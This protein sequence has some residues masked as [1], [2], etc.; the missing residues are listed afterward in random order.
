MEQRYIQRFRL[1]DRLC[2][3][4]APA[5]LA[6][7][8]VLEDTKQPR[9]VAQLKFKSVADR[10]IGTVSGTLRCLDGTGRT[11]GE[12]PFAY[13]DL[14]A[15]RGEAFGQYTAIVLP[16]T[17]VRA[18][19]LAGLE[20]CFAD[21]SAWTAPAKAGWE[22]LPPFE[23]L[24]AAVGDPELLA[25]SRRSLPGGK[26]AYAAR[27]GLWYC[28]CGGV[29]RDGESCCHRCGRDRDQVTRYAAPEGLEAL[30]QELREEEARRAE[31]REQAR[32][33]AEAKATALKAAAGERARQLRDRFTKKAPAEEALPPD[34]TAETAPLAAG[35]AGETPA[36]ETASDL[37]AVSVPAEAAAPRTRSGRARKTA[38]KGKLLAGIGVLAVLA[39][40]AA[41]VLPR[42]LGG[43]AGELHVTTPGD[44]GEVV[45]LRVQED[46]EGV[47]AVTP[48][49]VRDL[50]PGA[51][52]I[53]FG[54][55]PDLGNDIHPYLIN[56]YHM[57]CLVT[58]HGEHGAGEDW[59]SFDANRDP[60]SPVCLLVFG[61][62]LTRLVG[63]AIN[64]PR[65]A[66]GGDWEL[67]VT[68]CDY[69][70]GDLVEEETERF[71]AGRD[72]IF[73]HRIQAEDI[74]D[75]GAEWFLFGYNTGR[76][77]TLLSDDPQAYHIWSQYTS[78]HRDQFARALDRAAVEDRLPDLGR[79]RCFLL[80][81]DDRE[82]LGYTMLDHSGSGGPTG[83]SGGIE[84]LGTVDLYLEEENNRITLNDEVLQ[85]VIPEEAF[86]NFEGYAIDLNGDMDAYLTDSFHMA[87]L[88]TSEGTAWG[89][90]SSAIWDPSTIE[91]CTL[92]VYS[93]FT[94]LCGYFIGVPEDLG[95]GRWRIE[96]TL[97]DYDFTQLYAAQAEGYDIAPQLPEISESQL[98]YSGATWFIEP[99]QQLSG[100]DDFTNRVRLQ[101]LWSRATS[102]N[103]RL[104]ARPIEELPH[105][106][107][108]ATADRPEFYL[109][110]NADYQ[111][112]GYVRITDGERVE[113]LTL[114][115]PA[116]G[117]TTASGT[118]NLDLTA[119][120]GM[121]RLEFEQ[122]QEL[123]PQAERMELRSAADLGSIEEYLRISDST[124]W[125]QA[126]GEPL[127]QSN[128]QF[129]VQNGHASFRS[130]L[131]YSGPTRL[132]G[133]FIGE[134]VH[135]GGDTWRME[136]TLCDY[137]FS[138]LL[139]QEKQAFDRWE[140][141]PY[142][143][144]EDADTTGAKYVITG[145]YT[146]SE[147]E[148]DMDTDEE[149]QL[150]L[151]WSHS[152]RWRVERL[153]QNAEHLESLRPE[154][155]DGRFA[156]VYCLLLD[157]D[158]Q[159]V[160]YTILTN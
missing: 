23:P 41:V 160:A 46:E 146:A 21:G 56:S 61:Q 124:A 94:R 150:Y 39:V 73:S 83:G 131:I 97:C 151:L 9:L 117:G 29:N 130:L 111:Y 2:C 148:R 147:D 105:T 8:R 115:P 120:N 60:D 142:V 134:P 47:C 77:P 92:M 31:A 20:V 53:S 141:P 80:L 58:S 43:G 35:A 71:E 69:D 135:E 30:R 125:M 32:R 104:F 96:I 116:G 152:Q 36:S 74:A 28:T 149:A 49:L 6:A 67:D 91:L 93:D 12:V 95:G 82:L 1:P 154:G 40:L 63:Y 156:W 5:V 100:N 26:Y 129:S 155:P 14:T 68:L 42:V 102:P 123:I 144:P 88:V 38:G 54:G 158:Y 10:P 66:G 64:P 136:I 44:T 7:G 85:E 17:E 65:D 153:C 98:A 70:F 113:G 19:E 108:R 140:V 33:E 59:G 143:D 78:E 16:G 127:G 126:Y 86:F 132:C 90:N 25:L 87:W 18:V 133:Y 137:D 72:E 109:L 145:F 11:L 50:V 110:L 4:S 13:P 84:S 48:D 27:A 157:A 15:R 22:Q 75:S 52:S 139:D 106:A 89:G 3:S 159:P 128:G 51:D 103:I 45:T 57:A 119:I 112:L 55:V 24:E 76:G 101:S 62:D 79:W 114:E 121:C 122:V 37:E 81:D 34:E 138:D 107:R 118:V 99:V